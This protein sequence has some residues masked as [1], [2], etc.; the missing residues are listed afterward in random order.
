MAIAGCPFALADDRRQAMTSFRV[1]MRA[2][3]NQATLAAGAAA[4]A[5]L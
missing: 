3:M 2:D 5:L 4:F 1:E